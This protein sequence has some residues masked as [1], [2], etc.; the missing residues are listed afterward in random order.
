MASLNVLPLVF[1][2]ERF[3]VQVRARLQLQGTVSVPLHERD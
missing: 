3:I 1:I 2:G